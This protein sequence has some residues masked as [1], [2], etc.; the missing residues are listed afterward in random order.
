MFDLILLHKRTSK[1]SKTHKCNGPDPQ[2]VVL[3]MYL[4]CSRVMN[5]SPS[6]S[7]VLDVTQ[8]MMP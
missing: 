7:G 3:T 1:K 2:H 5:H 6:Y 8:K 4:S